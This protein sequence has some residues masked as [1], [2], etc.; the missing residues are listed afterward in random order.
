M[1]NTLPTIDLAA[2]ETISGGNDAVCTPDN[3]TGARQPTQFFE[4]DNSGPSLSQRV[5]ESTDRAM[6]PWQILN[7]L[8]RGAGAGAPRPNMPAPQ[9]PSYQ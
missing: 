2:L 9:R 8:G 6:R 4:N 7:G 5:I 3:P 1:S